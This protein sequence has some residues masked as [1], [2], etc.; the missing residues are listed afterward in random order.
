MVAR[1]AGANNE[2]MPAATSTVSNTLRQAL[3]VLVISAVIVA[4]SSLDQSTRGPSL[5][6][7]FLAHAN[8]F[9]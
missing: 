6:G 2:H 4:L 1:G 7:L 3:P 8:L 5:T 9:F